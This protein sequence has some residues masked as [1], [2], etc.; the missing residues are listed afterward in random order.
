MHVHARDDEHWITVHPN[1]K[2]SEGQP[3]LIEGSSEG[4]YKVKAGAG[5]KLNGRTISPG[6]MSKGR[7]SGEPGKQPESKTHYERAA[8]EAREASRRADTSGKIGEHGAAYLAHRTALQSEGGVDMTDRHHAAQMRHH[9]GVIA[10]LREKEADELLRKAAELGMEANT[11]KEHAAVTNAYGEALDALEDAGNWAFRAEAGGAAR[12]RHKSGLA[13]EAQSRHYRKA[14]AVITRQENKAKREAI[15]STPEGRAKAATDAMFQKHELPEIQRHFAEKFGLHIENGSNAARD[16]NRKRKA[17]SKEWFSL[18]DNE[19]D[20]RRAELDKLYAAARGRPG[21]VVRG[22]TETDLTDG[23]PA[24]KRARAVLGHLHNALTSL[25]ELGYDIP[26]ALKEAPVDFHPGTTGK[27]GGH[28][29]QRG[30]VGHFAVSGAKN[31]DLLQDKYRQIHERR[32]EAGVARWNTGNDAHSAAVHELA[33]AIGM[34]SQI[35]SPEKLRTLLGKLFP[36]PDG[37]M[38]PETQHAARHE[39]IKRNISQYATTNIFE[40][41]AELAATVAHPS[42]VRGTLPKELEDHVDALFHHRSRAAA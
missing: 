36:N 22:H 34:Q 13:R 15:R 14:R 18:S 5:G 37:R 9:A 20:E 40:T 25:G 32:M 21:K 41:D 11:A 3:L 30:G 8:G 4:G 16:L 24:A 26:A 38:P 6:S 27:F 7:Q 1:G 12:L 33:H 42:Y 28:A 19:R 17:L 2:G 23:S 31:D 29:W 10:D 39:W 35:N